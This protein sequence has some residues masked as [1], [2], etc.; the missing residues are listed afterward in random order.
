MFNA[1]DNLSCADLQNIDT[2]STATKDELF[3][4]ADLQTNKQST[5]VENDSFNPGTA[6][7]K[8]A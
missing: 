3:I 1:V 8:K 7:P 2:R 4:L 6:Q 5:Q